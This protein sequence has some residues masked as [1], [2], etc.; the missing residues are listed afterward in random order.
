MALIPNPISGL[1]GK[2]VKEAGSI[3]PKPIVES[4]Y[5]LSYEFMDYPE[6][7]AQLGMAY[8]RSFIEGEGSTGLR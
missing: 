1:Q 8:Y 7:L 6:D 4:I 3:L 2:L 5:K